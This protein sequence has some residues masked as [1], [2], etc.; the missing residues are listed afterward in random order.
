M[1]TKR[2][3][4]LENALSSSCVLL[5]GTVTIVVIHVSSQTRVRQNKNAPSP[6]SQA[7]SFLFL[8]HLF[9]SLEHTPRRQREW[10]LAS[11]HSNWQPAKQPDSRDAQP[12]RHPASH[13]CLQWSYPGCRNA[14][15]NEEQPRDWLG[16]MT[17]SM[18]VNGFCAFFPVCPVG[19]AQSLQQGD[20]MRHTIW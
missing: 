7:P 14:K 15:Q 1:D 11:F 8:R 5:R 3:N 2:T 9:L 20:L 10:I 18:A 4:A 6:H 17:P 19:P 16:I 13:L 12:P